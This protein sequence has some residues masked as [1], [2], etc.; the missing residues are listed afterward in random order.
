MRVD[1]RDARFADREAHRARADHRIV[2]LLAILKHQLLG[3]VDQPQQLALGERAVDHRHRGHHRAGE[4][5]AADL[6]DSG[7]AH[8]AFSALAT[9]FVTEARHIPR[10]TG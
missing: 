9:H 7:D 4:R 10:R 8:R 6:V 3:I 5:P 2:G 1:L